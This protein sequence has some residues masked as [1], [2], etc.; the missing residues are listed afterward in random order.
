MI[1]PSSL[2][3]YDAHLKLLG[4][5]DKSQ[6]THCHPNIDFNFGY[7]NSHALTLLGGI[8]R[9]HTPGTA[10][11]EHSIKTIQFT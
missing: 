6:V 4:I 8:R 9:K 7:N 2:L 5:R 3:L 11:R 10:L 1:G